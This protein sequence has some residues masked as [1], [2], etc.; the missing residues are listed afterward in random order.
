MADKIAII[1]GGIAGLTAAYLLHREHDITLFEKSGR[2][3]GNACMIETPEG[4]RPDI[5]VAAFGRAGYPN[6]YALLDEL[7]VKTTTGANTFMSFHN[8]ESKTGLYLTPSLKGGLRQRFQF[9]NPGTLKSIYK[10]ITGLGEAQRL[11]QKNGL[12]GLAMRDC[13]RLMK[14][15]PEAELVLI[16]VLCLMSS[17]S[18]REILQSPAEFF[19]DKL[20][21]HHDVVSPKFLY[22][23]RA[24][25]GGTETYV[26]ALAGHFAENIV[27]NARIKSVA[28]GNFGATLTLTDGKEMRFTR[29]IFACNADQALA[30]LADPTRAERKILGAWRYKE[31]RIVVHKDHARFPSK[32]LIQAY[33]YL[34]T[35]NGVDDMETSVNGAL[36]H[37][38]HV[39]EDCDYIATQHP[40]FPIRKDL[41]CYNAF[42]RTPIFDA[43]SVPTIAIL[44][45]LNDVKKTYYC[46]SHFGHGLH[47]DA[48]RSAV[49]VARLLGVSWPKKGVKSLLYTLGEN[50]WELMLKVK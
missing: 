26:N 6:F 39:D 12:A 42:L 31:G 19:V 23:V 36:W 24:I 48:V 35:G 4:D 37:E 20:R 25:K 38:P 32:E 13:L 18:C 45:Q 28:R 29:V 11:L 14:M 50:A 5:A 16:C 40:N 15:T 34:Y 17:M 1:G 49:D 41:T 33:T 27:L 3:G 44:P 47:E 43:A 8:L 9:L 30:L 10:L 21:V 22:S 2:V 7:G 46:G